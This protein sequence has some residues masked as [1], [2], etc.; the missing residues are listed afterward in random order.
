MAKSLKRPLAVFPMNKL[1]KL[2]EFIARIRVILLMM[3]ADLTTYGAVAPPLA[4]AGKHTDELVDGKTLSDT[5]VKGSG[6]KRNLLYDVVV[7]DK[8]DVM[9]FVQNLADKSLNATTALDIILNAGFDAKVNG[10]HVKAP[11]TPKYGELSGEILLVGTALAK[12]ASYEWQ[13][14]LDSKT[15][16]DDIDGT[17][18]AKT[19]VKGLT[20]GTIYFFRYRAL[21]KDGYTKWSQVV[22]IQVV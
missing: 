16:T 10:K 21:L 15:W 5:K 12:R 7:Q 17:L 18:Q 6:A 13:K 9:A 3:G 1:K 8:I 19:L 2:S 14:S 11:L 22:F 20:P 4:V